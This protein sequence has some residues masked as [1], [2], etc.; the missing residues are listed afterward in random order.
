[1]LVPGVAR[2]DRGIAVAACAAGASRVTPAAAVAPP[3]KRK[4]RRV[5]ALMLALPSTDAVAWRAGGEFTVI[6]ITETSNAPPGAGTRQLPMA[7]IPVGDFSNP[8]PVVTVAWER[9]RTALRSEN[10][11][12]GKG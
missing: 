7:G 3:V 4:E 1:M 11:A 6:S 10:R 5:T 9:L 12:A 8:R 2:R